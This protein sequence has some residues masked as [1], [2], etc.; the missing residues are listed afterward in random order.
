MT[1]GVT[2]KDVRCQYLKESIPGPTG[3]FANISERAQEDA[4]IA[5]QE[6]SEALKEALDNMLLRVQVAFQRMKRNK[7]NDTEQGKK[8][9]AEL[10]ELVTEARRILGGV[11]K[12][13]LELCKQYK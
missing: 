4:E 5:I 6:A 3:P 2:M 13:S 8:F 9:R 12:E 10:H 7:D 11:V 1:S